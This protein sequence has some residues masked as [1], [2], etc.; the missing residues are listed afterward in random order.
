MNHWAKACK[1]LNKGVKELHEDS[2]STNTDEKSSSS[3]EFIYKVSQSKKLTFQ[4]NDYQ[5]EVACQ[6][7]TGAFVNV[8]SFK[9]ICNIFQDPNPSLKDSNIK[10]KCFGDFLEP[11]GQI[12]LNCFPVTFQIVNTND[13]PLLS[14]NLVRSLT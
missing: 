10:L 8:I 7:N 1:N 2:T 5:E 14:A 4:V 11:I 12:T 9:D 3:K 6:M 13:N